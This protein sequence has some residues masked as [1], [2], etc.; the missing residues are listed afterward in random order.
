[1]EQFQAEIINLVILILTTCVGLITKSLM[2]FLKKKGI[3]AQIDANKKT[4]DIVVRAVEQLY[5]EHDGEEKLKL[6]KIELMRLLE[7]K[8]IKVSVADLDLLIESAIKEM[9]KN[10]TDT[11]VIHNVTLEST[12]NANEVAKKIMEDLNKKL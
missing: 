10:A 6:A 7:D 8:K 4:V 9:K 3:I 11:T 1:M 5:K 2:G 12:K